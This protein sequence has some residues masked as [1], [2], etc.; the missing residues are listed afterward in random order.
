[1]LTTIHTIQY[2]SLDRTP[3]QEVDI[4]ILRFA[5]LQNLNLSHLLDHYAELGSTKYHQ[6]SS[7]W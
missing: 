4:P 3:T 1:M 6:S 2:A 5:E 7:N